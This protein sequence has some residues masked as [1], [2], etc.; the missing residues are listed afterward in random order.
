MTYVENV[1]SAPVFAKKNG[2]VATAI[3]QFNNW[4][5]GR[6]VVIQADGKILVSGYS[7]LSN[8][9]F[10][11]SRYNIDGTLDESF[12]VS[13][14]VTTD[15]SLNDDSRSVLL[16]ADG[17]IISAGSVYSSDGKTDFALIQYN[18]DGSLDTAFGVDGKVIADIGE[19]GLVYGSYLQEDGKILVSGY[20]GTNDIKFSL[21]RYNS[22]GSVDTSFGQGGIVAADFPGNQYGYS[23]AVQ[24]DGKILVGGGNHNLVDGVDFALA[25]YHVDGSLDATFGSNGLVT[26]IPGNLDFNS[27]ITSIAVQSD[28]KILTAGIILNGVGVDIAIVRYDINGNLDLSFDGDGI[29]TFS[30]GAYFE[31][32]NVVE[33][34]EG[35]VL[36]VGSGRF[37]KTDLDFALFRLN[38]DG[39]LD[40]TFGDAGVVTTDIRSTDDYAYNVA[41]QS[42]GKI[43]VTGATYSNFDREDVAL[44][45]YN[46]DGSLDT[47]FG[48]GLNSPDFQPNYI[49]DSPAVVLDSNVTITDRDLDAIGA[50]AGA[51][52]TVKRSDLPSSDDQFISVGSLGPLIEGA[53]FSVGGAT[54]GLVSQ[55]S[56]GV[57]TLTFNAAATQ[58][59]VNTTLQSIAYRHLGNAPPARVS[60]DWIFSDGNSG[61]QGAGGALSVTGKTTVLISAVNDAPV[62]IPSAPSLSTMTS[63]QTDPQGQTVASFLGTTLSDADGSGAQGIAIYGATGGSGKWQYRLAGEA[64]WT[65][66]GA[67]VE[68]SALLLKSDDHIRWLN[69]GTSTST[70]R[71]NYYG[72]DQSAGSAGT[73]LNVLT[74][75]NQTAF[76]VASDVVT[77]NVIEAVQSDASYTLAPE[78]AKLILSGMAAISGTGNS[79]NNEITGNTATNILNGLGGNDLLKGGVGVDTLDGGSGNDTADFSD[80]TTS[81]VLKLDGSRWVDARVGSLREDRLRNIENIIGGSA[82]DI[83][84]GD[85]LANKLVGGDGDDTLDGGAGADRLV[86]GRGHDI[87]VVDNLADVVVEIPKEGT[88]LIRT[89]LV[90]FDL[91]DYANVENLTYTGM[92]KSALVG[93]DVGNTI[94]GGSKNDVIEGGGGSDLLYGGAGSDLLIGYYIYEDSD[95]DG[96]DPALSQA[97]FN[98]EKKNSTDSLYG[99]RGNDVYVMDSYVNTPLI[100]EY[101]GEGTDVIIGSANP[102]Y[103]MPENVENYINDSRL[104]A[105]GEYQYIEIIGNSSDNIIKSSPDWD[106]MPRDANWGWIAENV[107]ELIRSMDPDWVSY[108]KFFGMGGNDTLVGGAGNDHL[109]GGAGRDKITGGTGADWFIFDT[110]PN[111]TTNVDTIA[112]FKSSEGDKLVLDGEVFAMLIDSLSPENLIINTTGRAVESDDYLIFN[113]STSTLFYDADG[114]GRAAAIAVATL[115]GI[116]TIGHDDF[117]VM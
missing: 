101:R 39:S 17:K 79:L 82:S 89:T 108:E 78:E 83:L 18:S 24:S 34:P 77:L 43:V 48:Y 66:M 16:T 67:V 44:V 22:D 98:F 93:S 55:N 71:L 76:S 104:F 63:S 54:V 111:K 57:L 85:R 110:R 74:R 72:W 107:N 60:I 69:S 65:D 59:L 1:N 61:S 53:S 80:K 52:I 4:E 95:I 51:S 70:A 14:L 75:G 28:G 23:I 30:T 3:G 97:T 29:V 92:L 86:G 84:T 81:V 38:G 11:L 103:F 113:S 94:I 96:G 46:S 106:V 99:G 10:M 91:I 49:E 90:H 40:S 37:G 115:T 64:A 31:K 88:D 42:D 58:V 7:G 73:K 8:Y 56:A 21:V 68:N 26:T 36:V 114:S 13:G 9:D 19:R 33:Q 102:L 109:S 112:D 117:F 32:V 116:S 12:G 100:F 41:L 27:E 105:N 2:T 45:R 20:S 62:L 35:R 6:D 47:T 5:A 50:Y 87:Y 15:I 25:R